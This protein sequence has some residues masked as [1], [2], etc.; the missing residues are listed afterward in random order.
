M[1][2]KRAMYCQPYLEPRPIDSYDLACERY[3]YAETAEER[4]DARDEIVSGFDERY[5]SEAI[6][7]AWT[8]GERVRKYRRFV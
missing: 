8:A 4:R 6:A 5:H 1:P 3:R 7:H 2:E